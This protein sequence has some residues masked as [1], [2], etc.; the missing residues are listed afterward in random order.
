MKETVI[1]GVQIAIEPNNVKKNIEKVVKWLNKAAE[2]Y[3][4][5]LIIF[6]ETITTGFAT[7]LSKEELW[8]L[9]DTV[10]A[11]SEEVSKA[12]QKNKVHVVFPTYT[13]GEKMGDV[14]NSSILIGSNG[15]IIGV[16]NKTHIY[17]A[18]REWALPGETADVYDTPFA[19]VGM[20]I[21]YDGD[22]PELSRIL[23]MK[24]AE[25]IVRPSALLRSFEI[26]K[27]TNAARAYDNHVYLAGI[28][29]TGP[30]ATGTYY[31]GNSMIVSPIAQQ[32]ALA[33]AGETIIS[34]KLDPD[35]LKYMSYGIRKPMI[36]N[37]LEDRNIKVYEGIV[38]DVKSQFPVSGRYIKE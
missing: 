3:N 13:R 26:W 19:K 16:Y 10:P 7:G 35:P 12:A 30:D 27:L 9:V 15:D 5:D 32:L 23:A 24:G 34:A 33:T 21:C 8:D 14:Y 18:E 37:H 28:N 11:I 22:Y 4:P 20:I 2:E 6:P 38:K 36:F 17:P 31:F 25:I 1:A 29:A